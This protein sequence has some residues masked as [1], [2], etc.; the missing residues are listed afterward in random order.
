MGVSSIS[1]PRPPHVAGLLVEGE[2]V[3]AQLVV[4]GAGAAGPA[5]HRLHP[6]DQLLDRERLGDVVVDAEAQ[7]LDLVGGGVA[8]GQEDDR[9]PRAGAFVLAQAAGH[10]E[11]V[12]VGQ[13]DVEHDQVGPALL[14]GGQRLATGRGPLDLEAVVAEGEGD[15]LGDV[16][17]VVDG[18]HEGLRAAR[19]GHAIT[20]VAVVPD[21]TSRSP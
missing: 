9:H 19:V 10:L 11:A 16:L 6:L 13:H 17:L 7:A 14:D 18:Q 2:V 12:E 21:V 20:S 3:V 15:Q 8:C 1:R 5:Q 4:A